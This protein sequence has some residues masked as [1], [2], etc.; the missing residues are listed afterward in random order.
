MFYLKHV[1]FQEV[2]KIKRDS[3]GPFI[4]ARYKLLYF[5]YLSNLGFNYLRGW[6]GLFSAAW[7]LV[8]MMM[9]IT[10]VKGGIRKISTDR[11]RWATVAVGYCRGWSIRLLNFLTPSHI[12]RLFLALIPTF[13]QYFPNAPT[14]PT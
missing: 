10:N 1:V 9:N 11:S 3:K 7:F 8:V 4:F 6:L 12:H 5:R 14:T 2:W 13:L